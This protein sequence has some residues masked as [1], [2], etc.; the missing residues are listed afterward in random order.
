MTQ[1]STPGDAASALERPDGSFPNPGRLAAIAVVGW[2]VLEVAIRW[3]AVA[4]TVQ[5]LDEPFVG[6]ALSLLL[7][8]PA[9][10]AVLGWYASRSGLPPGAWDFE[11]NR[12]AIVA[13]LLASVV[14]FVL[15]S[16]AALVDAALFDLAATS[17]ALTG[18]IAGAVEEYPLIAV[19]FVLGN[20][21]FGPI[22]EEVVWRGI[23]QTELVERWGPALGI[24]VTAV[25]F[26]FKHVVV[27][28]SLARITTLLTLALVYGLVRHRWG[29]GAS[30]VT[31]V[32]VNL[33]A[34]AGTLAL[35]L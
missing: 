34:S 32:A 17:D 28:L 27:D 18:S 10:A 23:V 26:A 15:V 24:G 21:L 2:V 16:G 4:A 25:L 3:S 30:T 35:L 12:R 5:L 31:H 6:N 14:G 11:W 22:A 1:D 8:L 13:G 9:M 29:S 33:A 19:V 7:G 20:G